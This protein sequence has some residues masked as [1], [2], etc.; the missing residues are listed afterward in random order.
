MPTIPESIVAML[1]CARLGLI[2][3][4][5]FA[6]FSSN[7]LRERIVDCKAKIIITVDAFKRSG[8]IINSKD[9]VDNA[10]KVDCDFVKNVIVYENHASL[11]DKKS[12]DLVWNDILPTYEVNIEPISVSSDELLF[13]LYTSGS[14]GKP[15]GIMH[16][17]GGYLLNCI[18]TNKWVFDLKDQDIFGVQQT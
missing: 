15:K 17:S 16:A 4:V 14:T 8:K 9:I 13:I 5:V 18:I 10:I 12:R 2:H 11:S 3:S 6:G 7:A 1:S